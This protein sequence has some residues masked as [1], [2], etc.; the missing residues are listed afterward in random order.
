MS[1]VWCWVVRFQRTLRAVVWAAPDDNNGGTK[2]VIEHIFNQRK[3]YSLYFH[4]SELNVDVGQ[5]INM[6]D[7]IGTMGSTG[8]NAEHLHFEVRTE[9]GVGAQDP[10]KPFIFYMGAESWWANSLSEFQ[11]SWIDIS[12]RFGGYDAGFPSAWR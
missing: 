5:N 2:I 9:H 12:S 1:R 11:A 4:L 6:G 10:N 7:V 8:T 3:Y